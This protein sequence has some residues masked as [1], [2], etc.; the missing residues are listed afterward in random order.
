VP[1]TL[2][3]FSTTPNGF[4]AEQIELFR[5]ADIMFCET[6]PTVDFVMGELGVD[7]SNKKMF[8]VAETLDSGSVQVDLQTSMAYIEN[9]IDKNIVIISDDGF[10]NIVDPYGG[11]IR[12]LVAKNIHIG[13]TPNTSSL[14]SAIVLSGITSDMFFFGGVIVKWED[15]SKK[16]QSLKAISQ[17][18]P[19]I[20][21][22]VIPDLEWAK[23]VFS[24]IAD[25]FG[26]DRWATILHSMGKP[27]AKTYRCRA[28]E[29]YDKHK[30]HFPEPFTLVLH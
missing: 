14:L 18:M 4:S 22:I 19:I 8:Y 15:Y 2:S 9:N 6:K 13:I 1:V 23:V 11:L 12:Y 10:P 28:S 27:S 29:L 17:E 24:E 5:N 25:I 16:I 3:S 7:T 20:L 30:M 21:F 26:G